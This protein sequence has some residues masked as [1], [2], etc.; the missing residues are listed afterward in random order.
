MSRICGEPE[1]MRNDSIW[2]LIIICEKVSMGSER[3]SK[4]INKEKERQIIKFV[5]T[6]ILK[7]TGLQQ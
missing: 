7:L 3:R 4:A 5:Y 1:M 6:A 2:A